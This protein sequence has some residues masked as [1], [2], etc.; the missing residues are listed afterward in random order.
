[1]KIFPVS[2][3]YEI[4]YSNPSMVY[5]SRNVLAYRIGARIPAANTVAHPAPVSHRWFYDRSGLQIY[6]GRADVSLPDLRR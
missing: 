2:E 3:F 5:P 6:R 1:M 4:S